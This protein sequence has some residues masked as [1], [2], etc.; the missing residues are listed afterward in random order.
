MTCPTSL[1]I[2]VT[3]NAQFQLWQEGAPASPGVRSFAEDAVTVE[4][5]KEAREAR[6][7]RAVGSMYRTAGILAGVGHS[8]TEL[9]V[10]PKTSQVSLTPAECTM[11]CSAGVC[12]FRWPHS[13]MSIHL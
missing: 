4:L 1:A 12:K 2:A 6:R 3:H 7:R 8:S 11:Q 13:L 5:V 9:L 10:Q